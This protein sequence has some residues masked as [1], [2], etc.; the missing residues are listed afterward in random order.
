MPLFVQNNLS[1]HALQQWEHSF[2]AGC[3]FVICLST[4]LQ[5]LIL[6]TVDRSATTAVTHWLHLGDMAFDIFAG[7]HSSH[8]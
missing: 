6:A 3:I 8:S 5:V 7:T 1:F 2:T 4:S